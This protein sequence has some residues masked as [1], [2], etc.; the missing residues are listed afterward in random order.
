MHEE[1]GFYRFKA[2]GSLEYRIAKRSFR[3]GG[4]KEQGQ[5]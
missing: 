1:T 2:T 4:C 3:E 5:V